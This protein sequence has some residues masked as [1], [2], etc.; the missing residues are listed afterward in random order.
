M[1]INLGGTYFHI[2]EIPVLLLFLLA[3]LFYFFQKGFTSQVEKNTQIGLILL[4]VLCYVVA[5][6]LSSITAYDAG[7]VIKSTIKWFEVFV[8]AILVLLFS[9][10]W[11]RYK[12]VYIILFLA[13]FLFIVE[14]LYKIIIGQ[15]SFFSF[16]VFPGNEA[17]YAL[18][19]IFPFLLKKKKWYL[20]VIALLCTISVA[21][22]LS[23]GAWITYFVILFYSFSFASIKAR[24]LTILYTFIVLLLLILTPGV[25]DLFVLRWETFASAENTSNIERMALLKYAFAAFK[26]SPVL[27]VG[28]LNFPHYFIS[29]GLM[30]GIYAEK[31]E[32]LE[33]HNA[34]LQV[35]AEEGLVGL[36]FFSLWVF[37]IGYYLFN[38]KTTCLFKVQYLNGLKGFY[39]VL[40]SNL[41]YGY[42]ASQFRFYLAL[43]IGLTI[44]LGNTL[45]ENPD[46]RSQQY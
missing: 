32:I 6:L 38:K 29:E 15:L 1:L 35:A 11:K 14:V 46:E 26:E 27:G 34:F 13:P 18:A 3:I 20:L 10:T 43:F 33:P 45:R 17:L 24:K 9:S 41:L 16:R 5:V 4:S 42:I 37:L 2:L 39:L 31:Y 36:F 12:F 21:L 44:S 30:E 19:L 25:L 40:L 8:I 22:S 7:L 28:S 23:R